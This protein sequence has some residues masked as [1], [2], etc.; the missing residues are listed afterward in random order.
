MARRTVV[1]ENEPG[2]YHGVSRCVWRAFLCG[3]DSYSGRD[4]EHRK[5][6]VR[7]RVRELPAYS[8]ELKPDEYLN[9]DLK[10]TI[11]SD[12]VAITESELDAQVSVS[13]FMLSIRPHRISSFFQDPKAKYAASKRR[14]A[15]SFGETVL[16][17]V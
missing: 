7:N 17:V 6:W 10:Q 9:N 3:F 13:M 2:I 12:G 16:V 15:P 4:Y 14:A 1:P 11:A 5:S 8:P